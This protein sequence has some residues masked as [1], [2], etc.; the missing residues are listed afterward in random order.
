MLRQ[1]RGTAKISKLTRVYP[2]GVVSKLNFDTGLLAETRVHFL[3][4]QNKTGR[5]ALWGLSS[6]DAGSTNRPGPDHG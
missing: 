2:F 6:L 1:R 3:P 5:M 4:R